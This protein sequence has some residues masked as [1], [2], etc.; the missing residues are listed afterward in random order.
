MGNQSVA[1]SIIINAEDMHRDRTNFLK[2]VSFSDN[3]PSDGYDIPGDKTSFDSIADANTL[4]SWNISD[5][6]GREHLALITNIEFKDAP[7]GF[8]EKPPYDVGDGSWVAVLGDNNTG[9]NL[10][11]KYS[12]T[13]DSGYRGDSLF[14]ID[15]KLQ[16][17]Q[18]T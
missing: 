14:I 8:F 11:A 15:P 17:R 7:E 12:I 3:I 9:H 5:A 2:Y 18:K 1:V 6:S 13:F 16:I 4:I 10:V